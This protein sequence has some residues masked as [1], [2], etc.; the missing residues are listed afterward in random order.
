[1]SIIAQAKECTTNLAGLKTM[2][3]HT[4]VSLDWL[5]H[6]TGNPLTLKL[7]D[8]DNLIFF[9]LTNEKGVWAEVLGKFCRDGEKSYIAKTSNFKWGPEAPT[10]ARMKTIKE[11]SI[12][13]PNK[14]NL[15]VSVA[16][17]SFDFKPIPMN[18]LNTAPSQP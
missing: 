15:K 2:T 8:K 12:D 11:I 13:L 3:G 9:K 17:L 4:D 16:F 7:T 6:N 14:E 5:E 1:M 10:L 18:P